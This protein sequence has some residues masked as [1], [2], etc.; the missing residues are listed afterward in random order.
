MAFQKNI[1]DFSGFGLPYI[2]DDSIPL[3]ERNGFFNYKG[4]NYE[5]KTAT[6]QGNYELSGFLSNVKINITDLNKIYWACKS[7]KEDAIFQYCQLM[8]NTTNSLSFYF[9]DTLGEKVYPIGNSSLLSQYELY[10]AIV[11]CR[12]YVG[13]LQMF[14]FQGR[15][16]SQFYGISYDFIKFFLTE[17]EEENE[18]PDYGPASEPEGY[19]PTPDPTSEEIPIPD[20][21]PIGVTNVGFINVY[22]TS[23][24]AL[25]NLGS[26]LFPNFTPPEAYEVG[27]SIPEM[28]A[29]GFN[30]LTANISNILNSYINSNLINYIIDCHVIPVSPSSSGSESIKIGFKSFNS[31]GAKVTSDYI[32]FDCGTISIKE[33]YGNFIDYV[34]TRAQ[35]FLPFIGFVPIKNEYFQNGNLQVKYRFNIIDGSFMA[36][37]IS[38][39]SKS[40]LANSIVGMYGGNACVHIPITG[41][42][43][44]NMISGVLNGITSTVSNSGASADVANSALG[45]LAVKPTMESSNGYNATSSFLGIRYPYLIIEREVSNFSEYYPNE[46]GL[47]CNITRAIK[48]LSGYVEM[49]NIHMET[50]TCTDDE[51]TLIENLLK[52]GIVI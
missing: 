9:T 49:D 50:L 42:N 19:E 44:A 37:V 40:Q 5:F 32:D 29:Y 27:D 28:I 10:G 2:K 30:N 1:I 3:T 23:L 22:K 16:L 24:N 43:Y 46:E 47:P 36:F 18:D 4:V 35:L 15:Y 7:T 8:P 21:P 6:S 52:S 33:Y 11:E 20:V 14:Q 25:L 34:G 26:E 38:T 13:F 51:K 45:T 41:V 17:I 31:T 39:S 12:G 48:E